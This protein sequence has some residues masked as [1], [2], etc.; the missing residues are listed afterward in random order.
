MAHNYVYLIREREFVRNNEQT[1][2]LGKT[3][4]L[5]NSRLAGYPK[6]SE[7]ILFIDVQNCHMVEKNLME[8]FDGLFKQKKEYGREYYEGDL[9]NM[10]RTFFNVI[11]KEFTEPCKVYNRGWFAT[12]VY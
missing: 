8:Q 5:P 9:N 7:V 4:Q 3:T 2:K 1:Y 11:E 12:I 10:K 6:G